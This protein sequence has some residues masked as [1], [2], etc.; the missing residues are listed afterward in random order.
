M[1]LDTTHPPMPAFSEPE[2]GFH[3]TVDSA[4]KVLAEL[5]IPASRVTLTMAGAGWPPRSI[6][7]QTPAVGALIGPE[8]PVSLSV[9]GLGFFHSLPVGFWDEGGEVEPG[10]KEILSIVDDPIQKLWHWIREGARLFDIQPGNYVACERW[11]RLFGVEPDQ[12]SREYWYGL[13]LVLPTLQ[14]VAGREEGIR[15]ALKTV[16][17]L[18]LA[19]IERRPAFRYLVDSD[20]T[21]LGT[22][23]SRLGSDFILGDRLEDL[24][25][26]LLVI[27]P[28][29]LETYRRFEQEAERQQLSRLLDL[30]APL[31]QRYQVEWLVLDPDQAPRLGFEEHNA[32]LGVNSYLGGEPNLRGAQP[33]ADDVERR[34][35][36]I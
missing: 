7:D 12:W 13:A 5:G 21:L 26:L 25:R 31:Q 10:T 20:L 29:P 18:P 28:V 14:R 23:S 4:L 11:I 32:C 36:L 2:R 15:F 34:Q 1:G 17:N 30:C 19:G 27:G 9:S 22:K 3:H 33:F 35:L 6:V 24:A 8:V 16:F